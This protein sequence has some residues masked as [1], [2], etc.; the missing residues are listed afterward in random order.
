MAKIA[1]VIPEDDLRLIDSVASN[2]SASLV[3]AGRHEALRIMREREDAEVARACTL[4]ATESLE[5]VAAFA[6]TM[7]DGLTQAG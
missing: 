1:V 4:L 2:R 6:S 5:I 7:T 3:A